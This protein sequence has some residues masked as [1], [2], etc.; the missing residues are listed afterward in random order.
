MYFQRYELNFK[1]SL[2][3]QL[4][5]AFYLILT[6]QICKIYHFFLNLVAPSCSVPDEVPHAIPSDMT[7]GPFK[8]GSIITYTC[9][10]GYAGDGL[11]YCNIMGGWTLWNPPRCI[12]TGMN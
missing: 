5:R 4:K 10:D 9:E 7:Q 3:L 8:Y 2:D 1:S 12:P 6:S 11:I